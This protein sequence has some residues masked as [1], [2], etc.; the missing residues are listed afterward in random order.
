MTKPRLVNCYHKNSFSGVGDFFRG[1][2]SL[3]EQCKKNNIDYS[4]SFENHPIGKYLKFK[5]PSACEE[6]IIY[7]VALDFVDSDSKIGLHEF[8]RL[9]MEKIIE[10]IKNMDGG[11]KFVFSNYHEVLEKNPIFAMNSINS[12][13]LSDVVC[14]WFKENFY[15]S[16]EIKDSVKSFLKENDFYDKEFN[17]LHF[18]LGDKNTFCIDGKTKGL[19]ENSKDY[20]IDIINRQKGSNVILSDSNELKDLINRNKKEFIFPVL[21][22]DSRSSH[23]QKNTGIDRLE[24]SEDA[25]FSSA[26]D[27]NLIAKSQKVNSYSSYYWGTGFSC[28][29]SKLLSIPF[30]CKPFMKDGK[31]YKY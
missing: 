3:Y 12:L 11:S 2:V 21:V 25:C 5:G 1:S 29:I 4:L 22:S 28:W 14:S 9:Q 13:V 26:F 17:V 24:I 7:D 20:F 6:H 27:L 15:F 30:S 18:R 10:V 31:L 16:N 23:T 8:S 19:V